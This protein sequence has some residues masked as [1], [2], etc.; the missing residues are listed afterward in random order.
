MTLC[1]QDGTRGGVR[2]TFRHNGLDKAGR[3]VVLT[4]GRPN[5]PSE[6]AD[7][8]RQHTGAAHENGGKMLFQMHHQARLLT[9]QL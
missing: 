8:H 2:S 9:G 1:E 4:A 3:D 7:S 6:A 5:G